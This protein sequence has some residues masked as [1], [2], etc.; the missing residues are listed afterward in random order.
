[1]HINTGG[2]LPF[3]AD[4][5]IA[6]KDS[7]ND[8]M[9]VSASGSWSYFEENV[10]PQGC[11]WK[12]GELLLKKHSLLNA[13]EIAL[14]SDSGVES[15]EIYK[16]P[17]IAILAT[18]SEITDI[19]GNFKEKG[20]RHGSNGIYLTNL[21]KTL[22]LDASNF[23][24]IP[25]DSDLIAEELSSLS[26]V[27]DYIITIGGTGKGQKD[28]IRC[29]LRLCGAK[30]F[31]SDTKLT[32][33]LPFIEARL[34]KTL[35]LGLP[36]NPLGFV[37][38]TQRVL[39]PRLWLFYRTSPLPF[40]NTHAELGFDIESKAGE[41]CVE[42]VRGSSGWIALPVMKGTGRTS[43]FQKVSGVIPNPRGLA[44]P[45]GAQVLVE[46]FISS[47]PANYPFA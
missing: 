40:P 7:R 38:L 13:A 18:G 35:I 15:V 25:D 45:A 22:D 36:G 27:S 20:R 44:L 6:E 10:L 2:F 39:L 33:S 23:R 34:G 4:C 28:L 19:P 14:L 12:K 9:V 24:I 17:R 8:G 31:A 47:L 1:M 42:L 26:A 43:V 41:I 16:K 11:E 46:L 5:V 32:D 37:C 3:G 21:L 29:A 30:E